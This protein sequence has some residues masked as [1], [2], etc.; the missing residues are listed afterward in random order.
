LAHTGVYPFDFDMYYTLQEKYYTVTNR[1]LIYYSLSGPLE[2]IK[3]DLRD[4][5][6]HP[7]VLMERHRAWYEKAIEEFPTAYLPEW[8]EV[9]DE[10][11]DYYYDSLYEMLYSDLAEWAIFGDDVDIEHKVL[12]L[13]PRSELAC[14]DAIA[15]CDSI[16]GRFPSISDLILV[17]LDDDFMY[18]LRSPQVAMCS[19]DD[20]TEDGSTPTYVL[21]QDVVK[22]YL[23]MME[24]AR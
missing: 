6:V 22:D 23:D 9:K 18:V 5:K 19:D 16:L 10:A 24:S 17:S 2:E 1:D 3:S 7:F 8:D 4:G 14:G 21:P 13:M 20:A 12:T 15:L 11:S